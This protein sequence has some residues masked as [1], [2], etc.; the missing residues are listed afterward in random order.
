MKFIYSLQLQASL[1]SCQ[2]RHILPVLLVYLYFSII[3]TQQF[4]YDN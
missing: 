3:N 1:V 4:N 2:I